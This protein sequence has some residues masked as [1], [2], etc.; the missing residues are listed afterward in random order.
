MDY[1]E[2]LDYIASFSLFGSKLGLERL[3]E[4]LRRLGNPQNHLKFVHVAGTNGKGSTTTMLANIL[5]RAGYK[6][7]LYISPYVLCFRE[8]M[9]INGEMI[10]EGE[11]ADCATLVRG[12]V[13]EMA[14]EGD[15]PTEFEVETAIAFEWYKRSGCDIVCLEVG[16]GGRYDATNVIAPPELQI[17]TSISLDHTHIL[18]DTVAKIAYEKAGI[19]KGGVTVAYAL[20]DP[21]AL[22]VIMEECAKCGGTLI[23]PSAGAIQILEEGLLGTDFTYGET[24]LHASLPGRFQVYNA[25]TVVEAARQLARQGWHISEQDIAYGIAN[26]WFPARVEVLS[27]E[28]LTILDGAHNPSGTQALEQVLAGLAPR[29]I[30]V[31]MGMLADK[32]YETALA[33]I[34][35]HAARFIAVTPPNPR[36][37][38]AEELAKNAAR[39]CTEVCWRETLTRAVDLAVDSLPQ[40]GVLVMCGSLY[41]AAELRPIALER[42]GRGG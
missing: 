42:L 31:I 8:R 20:M 35:K 10:P 41:L 9:Q 39:Y 26:T 14:R 15:S 30:T 12:F 38:P 16:L 7:G 1:R 6:T 2:T 40:N 17:V 25:A 13:D 28:P 19:I 34:A 29:P 24:R 27:R 11:L 5:H 22:A 32:D 36:A 21:E 23:Q 18:G 33:C 4:L 3:T 37:L